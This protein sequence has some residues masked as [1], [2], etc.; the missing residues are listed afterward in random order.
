MGSPTDDAITLFNQKKLDDA[1]KAFEMIVSQNP[2]DGR[3]CFFLGLTILQRKGGNKQ[4]IDEVL[5]WMEKAAALEP[6]DSDILTT[7]GQISLSYA[8]AHTS[9]SAAG[10]GREAL[11]NAVKL[12]PDNLNA[13]QTLYEFY[14]QAPWPIG[15]SSKAAVQLEEIRKRDPDRGAVI[16]IYTKIHQKLYAEVFKFCDERLTQNPE[17]HLALF[18]YGRTAAISGQNMDMGLVRLRKYVSFSALKPGE[19]STANAWGRIGNIQEKL[20]HPAE[21]RAAYEAAVKLEPENRGAAE[22]LA[23]LKS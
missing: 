15:S 13:R 6:K 20:N 23:R 19:P 11:D 10:K 16:W 22:A 21:A 9:F 4:A 3:A 7:Y 14:M 8:A 12:N 5:P 17:D 1:Q 18:H 2:Q